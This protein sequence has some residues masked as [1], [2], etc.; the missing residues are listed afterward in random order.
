MTADEM[1]SV[2]GYDEVIVSFRLAT[3]S[4]LVNFLLVV[5]ERSTLSRHYL[6]SV[7]CV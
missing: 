7:Q 6:Y 1:Y 2:P 5:T 3:A 4:F